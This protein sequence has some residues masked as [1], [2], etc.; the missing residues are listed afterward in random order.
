[1][2]SSA[3]ARSV[4]AVLLVALASSGLSCARKISLD[5]KDTGKLGD[6]TEDPDSATDSDDDETD[7]SQDSDSGDDEGPPRV[8]PDF[9]STGWSEELGYSAAAGVDVNGD[10]YFDLLMG[11]G[12]ETLDQVE[13]FLWYGPL[14]G[15]NPPPDAT[16]Y[17]SPV[18]DWDSAWPGGA[19]DLDGDGFDDLTVRHRSIGTV[20]VIGGQA[21]PLPDSPPARAEIFSREETILTKNGSAGDINGDGLGDLLL[22]DPNPAELKLEVGVYVFLGPVTGPHTLTDADVI[23]SGTSDFG[24]GSAALGDTDGDGFGDLLVSSQEEAWLYLG[25]ESASLLPH[26]NFG[27]NIFTDASAAGDV[28]G[29]GYADLLLGAWLFLGPFPEGLLPVTRAEARF[30]GDTGLAMAKSVGSGDMNGDGL[31]DVAVR[32]IFEVEEANV[33][34]WFGPIQG[35]QTY[36]QEDIL[37]NRPGLSAMEEARD[38]NGDGLSDLLM[39]DVAHSSMMLLLGCEDW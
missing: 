20:L 1:M 38:T 12:G 6:D 15:D 17:T 25:S 8:A 33:R 18:D 30:L 34:L 16:L 23:L 24:H 13:A 39:G 22:A 28:N 21:G 36:G 31:G 5:S 32:D 4:P 14:V 29:D 9:T 35:E 11:N 26:S 19:G 7:D 27:P 3:F 10:G 37:V 2:H